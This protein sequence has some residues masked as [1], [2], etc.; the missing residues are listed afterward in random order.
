MADVLVTG[1]TG[2]VGQAVVAA[3]AA[4]GLALRCVIRRGT[5]DRLPIL[6]AGL[7]TVETDDLFAEGPEWWAAACDGVGTVIHLA[8]YAEPGK[9]LTSDRNLDCLSGTLSLA[10]GAARAG[11]KRFAGVGTCFEYDLTGGDLTVDTPLD[12][13][14]P[15]AAAKAS[16]YLTLNRW[17]PLQG[18]RFLWARLFY[19]HGEG[20]DARRLVPYLHGQLAA[21]LPADLTSGT[22]VR[23]FMD[24]KDAAQLIVADTFSA[25]DGATNI[26]SGRGITVR[27][28]AE[29]IADRYGRRD[30]LRFGARA[31]NL[32][33]PPR[34]VGLREPLR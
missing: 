16:A 15:Y 2:F 10:R 4:R 1:G 32:T 23:D 22:Q 28:L 25:R 24:V 9:Y 8:W 12:P 34:V 29:G 3:L 17:L 30:L 14:T 21:G 5:S 20:E 11:V 33:D 19:L 6:K 26:A 31:E 18:V 27:Q 13:L 7:D